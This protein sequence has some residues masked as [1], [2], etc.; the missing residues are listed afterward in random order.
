MDALS[1]SRNLRT[2]AS[3]VATSGGYN[4]VLWNANVK[5]P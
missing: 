1:I 2:P 4:D 5:L 3:L